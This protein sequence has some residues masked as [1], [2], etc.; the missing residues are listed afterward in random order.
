MKSRSV[1]IEKTNDAVEAAFCDFHAIILCWRRKRAAHVAKLKTCV[2][3]ITKCDM[4][5][6]F[7]VN[8][9]LIPHFHPDDLPT[10]LLLKGLAADFMGS[11]LPRVD[12][13]DLLPSPWPPPNLRSYMLEIQ[14]RRIGN[15]RPGRDGNKDLFRDP[16]EIGAEM[17]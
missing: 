7:F 13:L 16:F 12:K 5:R 2:P 10:R 15:H 14:H 3:I 8:E 9:I 1:A 17:H 4:P 6:D 11:P